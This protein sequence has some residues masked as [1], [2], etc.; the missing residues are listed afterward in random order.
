MIISC[1]VLITCACVG[2]IPAETRG[3]HNDNEKK[4]ELVNS[5]SRRGTRAAYHDEY[6]RDFGRRIAYTV[7]LVSDTSR[8]PIR[9]G[10][11]DILAPRPFEIYSFHPPALF[12]DPFLDQLLYIY[13]T[14]PFIVTMWFC[15]FVIYAC[16]LPTPFNPRFSTVL[17]S[18]CPLWGTCW[19]EIQRH[20]SIHNH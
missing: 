9:Q 3:N 14:V 5:T 6:P 18:I 7:S 17:K 4:L 1:T 8:P 10:R 16:A 2:K 12:S 20:I 13:E 19:F 15:T 11:R